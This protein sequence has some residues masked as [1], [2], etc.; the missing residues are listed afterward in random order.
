[1]SREVLVMLVL[2]MSIAEKAKTAARTSLCKTDPNNL[3]YR[4]EEIDYSLGKTIGEAAAVLG[5]NPNKL[6]HFNRDSL[7]LDSPCS[8]SSPLPTS[9][10]LTVM[11]DDQCSAKEGAYK[12]HTVTDDTETLGSVASSALMRDAD[13]LQQMNEDVLWG[14]TKLYRGMQLRTPAFPCV[15]NNDYDCHIVGTGQTLASIAALYPPAT[16]GTLLDLNAQ[17]LGQSL[18]VKPLMELKVPRQHKHPPSLPCQEIA[19][20][21]SCHTI[22]AGESLDTIAAM[23]GANPF[24]LCELNWNETDATGK[25]LRNP[26]IGGTKSPGNCSN[27]QAG[28]TLVVPHEQQLACTPRPGAWKCWTSPGNTTLAYEMYWTS[29]TMGKMPIHGIAQTAGLNSSFSAIIPVCRANQR[30]LPAAARDC[31]GERVHYFGGLGGAFTNMRFRMPFNPCIPSLNHTCFTIPHDDFEA[32]ALQALVGDNPS[33]LLFYED[34]ADLITDGYPF[35]EGQEI[36]LPRG[37]LDVTSFGKCR[38]YSCPGATS[39]YSICPQCSYTHPLDPHLCYKVRYGENL[40]YIAGR[41]GLS[42]QAL[43]EANSLPNCSCI[44]S[45]NAALKLPPPTTHQEALRQP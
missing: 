43:C 1:M 4:C 20:F 29:H 8:P 30:L 3:V 45:E 17:T 5:C 22:Q 10:V 25:P 21:W 24:A 34:N 42:V 12:C 35:N 28:A 9:G 41:M 11:V 27:I 37:S 7:D 14:E 44:P 40:S 33:D 26:A 18:V 23:I 6:C 36:K 2:T 39:F 16:V 19:G 38:G 31:S 32:T 13:L 15:D